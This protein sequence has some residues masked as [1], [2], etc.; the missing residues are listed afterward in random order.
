MIIASA[1]LTLKLSHLKVH[2]DGLHTFVD[3]RDR[4]LGDLEAQ[5]IQLRSKPGTINRN[6]WNIP[7][8]SPHQEEEEEDE[9]T[10]TVSQSYYQCLIYFRKLRRNLK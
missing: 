7:P 3:Q 6:A 10:D 8:E 5:L 1:F 9:K 4:A 2:I